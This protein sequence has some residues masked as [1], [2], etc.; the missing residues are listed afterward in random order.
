[1][2]SISTSQAAIFVPSTASWKNSI[3]DLEIVQGELVCILRRQTCV[4]EISVDL[5]PFL[6]SAIIVELQLFG[7][8]ERNNAVCKAL[9]ED[10]K[11]SDPAISVLEGVY[12][13]EPATH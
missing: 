2:H 4:G 13:L 7:Y 11:P 6:E 8:D 1:M 9:L 10:E 5:S 3:F 12:T